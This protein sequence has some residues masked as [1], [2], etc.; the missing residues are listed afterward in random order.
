[1]PTKTIDK[2]D[3]RPFVLLILFIAVAMAGCVRFQPEYIMGTELKKAQMLYDNEMLIESRDRA[4]QVSKQS[5]DYPAAKR[6]IDKIDALASVL[7]LKFVDIG[8]GYERAGLY[9]SAALYYGLALQYSPLNRIAK[10]KT[11]EVAEKRRLA[12]ASSGG[13]DPA[14]HYEKGKA[15]LIKKAYLTAVEELELVSRVAPDYKDGRELF[16]KALKEKEEAFERHLRMGIGY[17]EEE[18]MELAI[19]EWDKAL[20]LEPGS[21]V[22]LDYKARAAEVLSRLKSIRKKDAGAR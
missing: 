22:V 20:E 3:M 19:K 14:P 5:P 1:M 18:E 16:F 15:A 21:G 7:A 17:F 9:D 2:S 10:K 6:L 11:A 4:K 13:F 8:L 12:G